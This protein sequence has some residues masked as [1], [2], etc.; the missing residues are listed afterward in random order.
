MLPIRR[1][2]LL[3]LHMRMLLRK[4]AVLLAALP[5]LAW[6]QTSVPT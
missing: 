2:H 6:G 3:D 1:M 5:I 4:I